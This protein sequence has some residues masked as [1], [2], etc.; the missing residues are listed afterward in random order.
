MKTHVTFIEDTPKGR[1]YK[2]SSK[3]E[4]RKFRLFWSMGFIATFE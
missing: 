1:V 3:D 2:F 4:E